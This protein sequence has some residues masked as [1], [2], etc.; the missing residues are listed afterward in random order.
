MEVM[1]RHGC[2]RRGAEAA[3]VAPSH[4]RT[5]APFPPPSPTAMQRQDKVLPTLMC[6]IRGIIPSLTMTGVNGSQVCFASKWPLQRTLRFLLVE[7]ATNV[8]VK[9]SATRTCQ[10]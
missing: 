7:N 4:T 9:C 2:R 8:L 5:I 10:L 1:P 3:L 6:H